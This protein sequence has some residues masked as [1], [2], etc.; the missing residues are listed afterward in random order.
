M[1]H[2]LISGRWPW[3]TGDRV[4]NIWPV[5]ALTAGIEEP[6]IG[7]EWRFLPTPPALDAPLGG[8]PL[9]YRHP[10]W[11]GKTTTVGL[12]DGEKTFEDI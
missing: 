3:S 10:V 2:N 6:Y 4:D 9:E 7:S 8:V 11:Y 5:T 12:P 1:C